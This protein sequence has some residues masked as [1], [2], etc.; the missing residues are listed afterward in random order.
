MGGTVVVA[1]KADFKRQTYCNQVASYIRELI[2]KGELLP[3]EPVKEA[4]LSERLGISRA[5]VREALQILVQEGVVTSEPQKGKYVRKITAKEIFNSYLVDGILEGAGVAASLEDW[6]DA[7]RQRLEDILERMRRGL[8][9][10]TAGM[11]ETFVELDERF[12]DALLVRCDNA[13]LVKMARISDSVISKCLCY[14]NL[15]SLYSPEDFFQR[16]KLVADAVF[17]RDR[18][19]VERVLREHYRE[20]GWRMAG[21]DAQSESR[22][23]AC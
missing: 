15:I 10:E 3:G 1:G 8:A 11:S 22:S 7:D 4:V 12:H 6:D 23:A 19:G 21:F 5:P 2:R 16:H 13:R 18:A 17:S 14:G 9:T 20:I